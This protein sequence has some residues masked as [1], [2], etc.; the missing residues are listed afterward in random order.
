M[1]LT[2]HNTKIENLTLKVNEIFYSLQGEGA[3][4]GSPNIFIRLAGCNLRCAFC[5]TEF[6]SFI[7]LKLSNILT[8]IQKF[9]CKNIIWTGG[10]PALQLT[11][12]IV[13]Y[14]KSQG[15]F[16]AIETNGMFELPNNLDWITVSPKSNKIVPQKIN[17]IKCLIKKGDNLPNYN[18]FDCIK[19]LSPINDKDE[20]NYD[21]LN[22]CIKL[23]LE[24]PK[25]NLTTQYHKLWKIK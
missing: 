4:A 17:E 14:F 9:N 21:N 8:E 7:T 25:W 2:Q 16:Q 19:W 18:N 10:E 20:I 13:D 3:R 6:E 1:D 24:N 12:D 15:Y 5:D 11:Y 23:V 22:Y